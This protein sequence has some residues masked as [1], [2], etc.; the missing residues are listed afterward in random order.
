MARTEK[1]AVQLPL[2]KHRL[3]S[4][5]QGFPG[6]PGGRVRRKNLEPTSTRGS[7]R[8][9]ALKLVNCNEEAQLT[10]PEIP[11]EKDLKGFACDLIV[12]VTCSHDLNWQT[13]F[14]RWHGFRNEETQGPLVP[15]GHHP[16]FQQHRNLGRKACCIG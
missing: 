11:G 4:L 14:R 3:S 15:S 8:I 13:M 2:R 5:L 10:H 9:D 16:D 7:R 1:T 6:C 12:M